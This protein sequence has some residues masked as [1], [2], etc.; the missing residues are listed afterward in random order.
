MVFVDF[1]V[2]VEERLEFEVG[3]VFVVYYFE[4]GLGGGGC[5]YVV[6][7]EMIV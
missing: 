6:F 7:F 5:D 4:E 2:L 1:G 3:V